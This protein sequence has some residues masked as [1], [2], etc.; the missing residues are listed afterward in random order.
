MLIAAAAVA[1]AFSSASG[2]ESP[3]SDPD[4]YK[5]DLNSNQNDQQWIHPFFD[6]SD[7]SAANVRV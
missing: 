5:N 3:S 6:I 7:F 4:E 1:V 2:Q